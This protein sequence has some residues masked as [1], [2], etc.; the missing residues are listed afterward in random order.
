VKKS[1]V[2]LSAGAIAFAGASALLQVAIAEPSRPSQSPQPANMMRQAIADCDAW[3][4]SGG[5]SF[6]GDGS[7]YNFDR[8]NSLV[9][10]NM[11]RR[12]YDTGTLFSSYGVLSI[13]AETRMSAQGENRRCMIRTRGRVNDVTS[14]QII[15][16]LAGRGFGSAGVGQSLDSGLKM[17]RRGQAGEIMVSGSS[18]R[19]DRFSDILE[20]QSTPPED[21]T[22]MFSFGTRGEGPR[23]IGVREIED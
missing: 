12:V 21:I 22:I 2:R 10:S 9:Q 4:A 18:L 23:G 7:R 1:S 19:Y 16:N 11:T 20:D 13:Y 3:I 8:A 17:A 15:Q 6:P 14:E 5:T